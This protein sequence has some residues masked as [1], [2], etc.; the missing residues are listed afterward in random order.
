[1]LARA[2]TALSFEVI[3]DN[4][5][6]FSACGFTS[7]MFGAAE[8]M[9]K[10]KS[11]ARVPLDFT[12]A[13]VVSTHLV[14]QRMPIVIPDVI[15]KKILSTVLDS[16]G[17]Y[18]RRSRE[19]SATFFTREEIDQHHDT[20]SLVEM[21]RDIPG[22]DVISPSG[23]SGDEDYPEESATACPLT[24]VIH[25]ESTPYYTGEAED[26]SAA[27]AGDRFGMLLTPDLIEGIEVYPTASAIP[28]E[29]KRY[30]KGCGMI[31][32]WLMPTSHR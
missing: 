29:L 23:R 17:F 5:G 15:D 1:M 13:S 8:V 19:K 12:K 30:S 3:T 16:V 28:A 7:E 21:F 26:S 32:A 2:P 9:S 24:F 25:G 4:F 11:V 6:Q 18:R 14:V 10:R 27:N 31:V 22:I 20:I